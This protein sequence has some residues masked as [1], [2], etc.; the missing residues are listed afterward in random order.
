M[1]PDAENVLAY[2]TEAGPKKWFEKDEAFDRDFRERF[3]ALHERAAAGELDEDW[4]EEPRAALALVIL[5]DQFP[6]NAFRGSA[7]AFATDAHA[8]RVAD[9]AIAAGFESQVPSALR[10]FFAMPFEHSE[11][12]A[13][14]DRSIALQRGLGTLEWAEKHREIIARFGRFPHRNAVLG[15]ESSDEER[16]F[17]ASGGFAG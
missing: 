1:H 9:R 15:R 5:L 14:Q 2:W 12:L 4:G 10:F 8:R 16:A 7:R 13:D 17:L 11:S 6:R 3:L